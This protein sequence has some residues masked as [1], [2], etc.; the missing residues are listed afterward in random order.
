MAVSKDGEWVA[1]ASGAENNKDLF[2]APSD[3]S[4]ADLPRQVTFDPFSESFPTFSAD[5]KLLAFVG[6]SHDVKGDIYLLDL[7]DEKN[8]PIRLT[9]RDGGEGGPSFSPD[10]KRLYF[11][12]TG[13]EGKGS[14]ILYVELSSIKKQMKNGDQRAFKPEIQDTGVRGTF[15]A[16]SPSGTLMACINYENNPGGS[17]LLVDLKGLNRILALD[18][19][20]PKLF[21]SWSPD[22]KYLF[23]TEFLSDTDKD[24][25]ITL[26]DV[27]SIVRISPE[28]GVRYLMT[29][30][31]YSALNP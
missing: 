1:Y 24:G 31:T 10:G 20:S 18:E 30:F 4:T 5:G 19:P 11:H 8:R 25:R 13:E 23:F 17:L 29:P 14:R 12:Q 21:P 9:G 27:G 16:L 15:P 22:G 2:V 7:R 28:T 26:K 3:P 6:T